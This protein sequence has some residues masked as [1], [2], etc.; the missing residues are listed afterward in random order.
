MKNIGLIL[1]ALAFAC[2]PPKNQNGESEST[3]ID[4]EKVELNRSQ[5]DIP[6]STSKPS[7][8]LSWDQVTMQRLEVKGCH[9]KFVNQDKGLMYSTEH[10]EGLYYYDLATKQ[11][12]IITEK[13]GAGYQP[14]WIDGRII[15]QVKGKMKYIECFDFERKMIVDISEE[16]GRYSPKEFVAA[17]YPSE[18]ATLTKDLLAIELVNDV[19]EKKTIQP[20]VEGNYISTSLSPNGKMLL[21]EVAGLGGFVADLSGETMM[22]IGNVDSPKWINNN[23]IVFAESIDDGMKVMDS[24]VCVYD[25]KTG[26]KQYLDA[27]SEALY[28]PAVS[29]SGSSIAANTQEGAIYIFTQK[30]PL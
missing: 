13:S 27:Q 1:I 3:A 19:G 7:P 6:E 15:Y 8:S 21:Y 25:L 16:K 17:Q 23:Q 26:K 18:Y 9:V 12:T 5:E 4:Y 30:Q 29:S 24:K 11:T 2:S 20:Q 22:K 10:Y 28:E 14:Q